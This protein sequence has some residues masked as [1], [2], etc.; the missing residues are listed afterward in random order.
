L[1]D[2]CFVLAGSTLKVLGLKFSVKG[3]VNVQTVVRGG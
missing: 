1:R 2:P 3:S